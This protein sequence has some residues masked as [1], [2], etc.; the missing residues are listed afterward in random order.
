M[1]RARRKQRHHQL[2]SHHVASAQGEGW[3]LGSASWKACW[4]KLLVCCGVF[5]IMATSH[6]SSLIP[7]LFYTRVLLN[8]SHL[9]EIFDGG[10]CVCFL[11]KLEHAHV[12]VL[13]VVN[14]KQAADCLV[15]LHLHKTGSRRIKPAAG[16]QW[17][18]SYHRCPEDLSCPLHPLLS[19]AP[20]WLPM[21]MHSSSL[22]SHNTDLFA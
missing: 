12:L 14:Q 8:R 20:F 6:L 13:P 2:I 17:E 11:G 4:H 22:Y 15:G 5:C 7:T 1:S 3:K 9:W 10:K 21:P 18:S 16:G 19:A